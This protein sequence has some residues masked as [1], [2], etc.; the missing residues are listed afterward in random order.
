MRKGTVKT[1]SLPAVMLVLGCGLALVAALSAGPDAFAQPSPN[2]EPTA[3]AQPTAEPT[4]ALSVETPAPPAPEPA[5]TLD[6]GLEPLYGGRMV[7]LAWM[8]PGTNVSPVP[9]DEVFPPQ[10]ITIRFNH[11][12]HLKKAKPGEGCKTCHPGAYTSTKAKDRLMPDP[13]RT[14]DNCHDVDHSSKPPEAGKDPDGQ[15]TYCHLGDNAGK[16]GRV[17]RMIIPEANLIS[18]HK[19]HADRHIGCGHCHGQ[20]WKLELATREQLPRMAGCFS[21]HQKPASSRGDAKGDCTACHIADRGG[22]LVTHFSTGD[23]TPPMWLHGAAHTPDFIERHKAV[24]GANSEMCSSCHRSEDCTNC[25]DGNVRPRRVH[26]NDWISMHAVAGRQDNPR[27]V[28]CHQLVSFCGDCHR[29]VGVARDTPS[30]NRLAGRRFHPPP[31][32]WTNGPR[33]PQHHAFEAQRNINACVSCHTER[34]CATCHATKGI[35]GGGGVNPHP[36]GFT[37]KCGLAMDRN[38]RPCLVCHASTDRKLMECQ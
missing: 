6:H 32:T 34:D 21:C 24:A 37:S 30:A 27:C 29:R 11:R 16:N 19:V 2:P 10:T 20:V 25:H 33:S 1:S 38:P 18:N 31:Q 36:L 35:R 28:S 15:C 26:P 17:A 4:G 13:A 23:L 9:S 3:S 12:V 14:C 7:P 5:P 8:P 22:R